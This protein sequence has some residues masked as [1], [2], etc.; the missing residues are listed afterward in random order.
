[1]KLPLST[2]PFHAS[3]DRIDYE[4]K[5]L[6]VISSSELKVRKPKDVHHLRG[7]LGTAIVSVVMYGLEM[8]MIFSSFIFVNVINFRNTLKAD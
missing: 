6:N 2:K 4:M 7:I 3:Q 1:M 5:P 8:N